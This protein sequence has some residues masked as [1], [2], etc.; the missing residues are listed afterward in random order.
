MN[1]F[2][3]S[4]SGLKI[5]KGETGESR[6]RKAMGLKPKGHDCQVAD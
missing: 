6:W 3:S 2:K 5:E 1:K 4:T